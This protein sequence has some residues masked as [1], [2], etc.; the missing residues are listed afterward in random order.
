[1]KLRFSMAHFS[2]WQR[3]PL[4][5]SF[6]PSRRHCR[7]TGPIY[8]AKLLSPYLFSLR[9]GLRP[10]QAFVPLKRSLTVAA[11]IIAAR[12][13]KR[14]SQL[15]SALLGRTA[16]VVRDGRHILDGADFNTDGA[17]RANRRFAARTGAGN[18]HFHHPQPA[19]VRLVG[20]RHG[21]LLGGE[22]RV[23]ARSAK[24]ERTGAGP[25][26]RV[27]FLIADGHD[28]VVEGGLDMHDA[29]VDDALFLLLEALLLPRF[30]GWFACRFAC[31]F[32][33]FNWCFCH[34]ILCLARRLLLV[35]HGAAART[36]AG[37]GVGMRALPAYRQAAA[38]PQSTVGTH[39]D[40]PLDV[41][42]DFFAQVA[43]DRAFF[44][45]NRTNM[46][47]FV[48]R[49]IANFLVEVNPA[50]VKQRFRTGTADAVDV[51]NPDLGSL[52]RRQIH[53]G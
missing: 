36:L 10:W 12:V 41:H 32:A 49:Q 28:G 23:L 18:A 11:P 31:R 17:Q 3:S 25:G 21:R 42:R 16:P 2:L 40:V 50:P 48:F 33:C 35:R 20:R 53:T 6:M 19:F 14:F 39:L 15:H 52:P 7:Q 43:F 47:D 4:R 30:G 13:S 34:T 38:V 22:G 27:A 1:M 9:C 26:N 46:V 51:A 37:A 44:F 5:Y 29:G 45:Q 24:A 8:L